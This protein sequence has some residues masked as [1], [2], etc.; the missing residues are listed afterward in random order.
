MGNVICKKKKIKF[1]NSLTLRKLTK[2]LKKKMECFEDI[3]YNT[4]Q[5]KLNHR[6][7]LRENSL[8][9]LFKGTT[10]GLLHFNEEPFQLIIV[11]KQKQI[12]ASQNWFS[13]N[14]KWLQKYSK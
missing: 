8:L 5:I 9:Q 12:S 13:I 3:Y 10:Y 6:F 2:T 1:I 7:I 14:K 11:N 4:K